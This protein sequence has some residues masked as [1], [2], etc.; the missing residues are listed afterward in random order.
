MPIAPAGSP[1]R[2]APRSRPRA[3]LIILLR[4]SRAAYSAR[5]GPS[6]VAAR[7]EVIRAGALFVCRAGAVGQNPW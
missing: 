4:F 3:L 7:P 2:R 1:L 5:S 6:C